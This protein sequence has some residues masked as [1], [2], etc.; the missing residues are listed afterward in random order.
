MVEDK[1]TEKEDE[2]QMLS[3]ARQIKVMSTWLLDVRP[4]GPFE[5]CI[6]GKSMTD[7]EDKRRAK[8]G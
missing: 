3:T 7:M 2:T 1:G 4:K 8:E 5:M 6:L